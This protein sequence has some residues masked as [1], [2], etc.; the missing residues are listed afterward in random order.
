MTNILHTL[1][2]AALSV[3]YAGTTIGLDKTWVAALTAALYLLLAYD[4]GRKH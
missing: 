2:Y 1:V 4:S 3:S